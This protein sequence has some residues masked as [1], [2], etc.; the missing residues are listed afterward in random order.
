M[1][2]WQFVLKLFLYFLN[3]SFL[4]QKCTAIKGPFKDSWSGEM[5]CFSLEKSGLNT[6]ITILIFTVEAKVLMF[7]YILKIS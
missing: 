7:F 2:I 6:T 5:K 3:F 4:F 1:K